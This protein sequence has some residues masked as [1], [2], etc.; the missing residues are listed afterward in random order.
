MT[1]YE[2]V[3]SV[4]KDDT[5]FLKNPQS[6]MTAE[7]WKKAPKLPPMFKSFQRGLLNMDGARPYPAAG[8]GP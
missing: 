5:R 1:R 7:Q 6:A 3:L 8:P 4:L 2:D